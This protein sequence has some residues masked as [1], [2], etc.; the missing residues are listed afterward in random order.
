MLPLLLD[1][2]K[3]KDYRSRLDDILETVGL[4]ERKKHTPESYPGG[5]SSVSQLRGLLLEIPRCCLQ[6]SL[7]GI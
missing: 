7:P 4:A 1:G 6:T 3:L 5:S 2:K